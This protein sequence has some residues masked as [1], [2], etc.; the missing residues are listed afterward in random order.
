MTSCIQGLEEREKEMRCAPCRIFKSCL[1]GLIDLKGVLWL[2]GC[3]CSKG[4][5][6]KPVNVVDLVILT[7]VTALKCQAVVLVPI[8]GGIRIYFKGGYG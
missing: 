7:G 1:A 6:T 4:V 3:Q 5:R 2:K 8:W